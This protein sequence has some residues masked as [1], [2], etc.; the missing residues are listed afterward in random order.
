M[1]W[2]TFVPLLLAIALG[3]VAAKVARDTLNKQ[4]APVTQSNLTSIVVTKRSIAPG[5]EISQDDLTIGQVSPETAPEQSFSNISDVLNRTAKVEMVKGQAIVEPLLAERGTGSGL[6]ALVPAGMRAITIEV[7]EFSGVAGMISPGSRVDIVATIGASGNDEMTARTIVQNVKITAIGQRVTAKA[8]PKDDP[9]AQQVF[10]SATILCTPEEAEAI[11]L[12]HTTGRPW[13]VLRGNKDDEKV[14]TEGVTMTALR[15]RSGSQSRKS[16]PFV[17]VMDVK[18]TTRPTQQE[19]I[20]SS[21]TRTIEVI[22]GGTVSSV[23]I[24]LPAFRGG[25]MTG[26]NDSLQDAAPFLNK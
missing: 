23:T 13:L 14:D 16:D 22:R 1:N 9:N 6:Q 26:G 18:P 5:Q 21:N 25:V 11:E 8:D 24:T 20:A 7:N 2:K 4:H 10:R 3:L 12:A 19:P 15:G 17:P